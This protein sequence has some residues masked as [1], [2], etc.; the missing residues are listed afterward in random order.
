MRSRRRDRPAASHE[1]QIAGR[2][3]LR[4]EPVLVDEASAGV[5]VV[6][7]DRRLRGPGFRD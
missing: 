3:G 1:W 4:G 5:G 6:G 7:N 2:R